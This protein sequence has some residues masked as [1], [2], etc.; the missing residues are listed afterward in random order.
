MHIPDG[1]ESMEKPGGSTAL[2][3]G[4]AGVQGVEREARLSILRPA[5]QQQLRLGNSEA[6]IP[7][8][9]LSH[10][11]PALQGPAGA[12]NVPQRRSARHSPAGWAPGC[13]RAV[14]AGGQV[15][16][17]LPLPPGVT[18]CPAVFLQGP[19]G[20]E[21]LPDPVAGRAREGAEGGWGGGRRREEDGEEQAPPPSLTGA[22][23][24][25]P[26]EP[27]THWPL[28]HWTPGKARPGGE[29]G[30]QDSSGRGRE[31]GR[32]YKWEA[33]SGVMPVHG[34]AGLA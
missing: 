15:C 2:R 25:S 30:N 1:G 31:E 20:Q 33:S 23:S 7:G 19:R 18:A 6:E 16:T 5:R 13:A 27:P 32:K 22:A 29:C 9:A 10:P 11:L 8:K 21:C 26:G 28:G 24:F 4:G 34:A 17:P 14:T 3:G 12:L